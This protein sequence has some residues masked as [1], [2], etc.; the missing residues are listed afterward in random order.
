MQ[1]FEKIQAV[2]LLIMCL[3]A[4][5]ILVIFRVDLRDKNEMEE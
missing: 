3:F 5:I 4:V 2:M 1:I